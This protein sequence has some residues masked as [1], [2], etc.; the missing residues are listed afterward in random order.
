VLRQS[1]VRTPPDDGCGL[2]NGSQELRILAVIGV[3]PMH[4][5]RASL[6]V[7]SPSAQLNKLPVVKAAVAT[8]PQRSRSSR[9]N[10]RIEVFDAN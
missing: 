8:R 4:I 7:V 3:N 6:F 2:N 1:L 10:Q 9:D 5:C